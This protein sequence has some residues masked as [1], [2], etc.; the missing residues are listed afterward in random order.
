MF[1][2]GHPNCWSIT[3]CTHAY[4]YHA[5]I[6]LFTINIKYRKRVNLKYPFPYLHSQ[7]HMLECI[8]WNKVEQGENS[9]GPILI[10]TRKGTL[11]ETEIDPH[12]GFLGRGRP[13]EYFIEVRIM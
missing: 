5:N 3:I 1:W 2:I 7:G 6:R 8:G 9:T 11:F 10:G 13:E 12:G 4:I